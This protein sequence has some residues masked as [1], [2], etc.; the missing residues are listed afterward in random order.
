[1]C[2]CP[3]SKP[4]LFL[5]SVSDGDEEDRRKARSLMGSSAGERSSEDDFEEQMANE[6][7]DM[8]D[9]WGCGQGWG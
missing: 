1:M 6:L 9:R 4:L 7:D 8:I 5:F 2:M 3:V